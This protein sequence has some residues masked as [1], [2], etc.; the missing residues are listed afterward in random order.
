MVLQS[1]WLKYGSFL[2][3]SGF[4]FVG[5]MVVYGSGLAVGLVA[6]WFCLVVD[7]AVVWF[8]SGGEYGCGLVVA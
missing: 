3:V 8:R 1:V 4:R 7:I 5:N 2:V 6:V